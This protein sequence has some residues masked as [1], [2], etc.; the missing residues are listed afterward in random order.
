MRRPLWIKCALGITWI[1]CLVFCDYSSYEI[2]STH[3][4]LVFTSVRNKFWSQSDRTRRITLFPIW[5]ICLTDFQTSQSEATLASYCPTH[6]PY[7][8]HC[9]NKLT[10]AWLMD[11]CDSNIKTFKVRCPLLTEK[12]KALEV[13]N[14]KNIAREI[15]QVSLKTLSNMLY[16]N[17]SA[18]EKF[19]A[20]SGI[21]LN[22][23]SLHELNIFTQSKITKIN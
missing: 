6:W 13:Y 2:Y 20:C 16:K 8:E 21:N 23:Y 9:L 22:L 12:L 19:I 17:P 7:F 5:I 11:N 4:F 18:Q 14:S 3:N 15:V 10:H 1:C